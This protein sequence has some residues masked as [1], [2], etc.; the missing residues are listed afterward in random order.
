MAGVNYLGYAQM[1]G[2]DNPTA[3]GLKQLGQTLDQ[4]RALQ[5]QGMLDQRQFANDQRQNRLS[6][7]QMQQA[8]M[9]IDDKMAERGG[10]QDAYGAANPREMYAK[11]FKA[12]Q[13]EK[14]ASAAKERS[15]FA[16]D[17]FSK[18]S[19]AVKAGTIDEATADTYFHSALKLNGMDLDAQGIKLSFKKQ[20]GYYSGP[21]TEHSIFMVDGKPVKY[22]NKGIVE[23]AR[24]VGLDPQTQEPIY[25]MDKD[26]T[27]KAPTNE[28]NY[29]TRNYDK[30]D[31]HITEESQ[32]GGK[33]WKPLA[34]AP[35]YKPGTGGKTSHTEFKDVMALRKEFSSLPEVKDYSMI[36]A[37]SL[38]AKKALEESLKNRSN[39]PVDQT[40]ITT[41]NKLLDPSSVVR[42]SEYAR[43]PQDLSLLS[44]IRGK[45][46]K[47]QSGG[48]GLDLNERQAILR[49]I[50]NFS[51]IADE[52]YNDQVS[53]YSE[54]AKRNGFNPGDVIRLG[55]KQK[56][57]A[58]K[59][60]P[61][62]T[63]GRFTVVEVP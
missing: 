50:T 43:T 3:D 26:T 61:P 44:R 22:G 6:D 17:T 32:D 40:V 57:Q 39:M 31:Q 11:K 25:Q 60:T 21:V 7:L 2:Q 27:F 20:G 55:H 5:R 47:V 46:D 58:G 24:I 59:A 63:S 28:N 51:A 23:K 37:Q 18:V 49:M 10:M 41:F 1:M 15:K 14:E 42:E 36:Q 4:N 48:A 56:P 16:L 33:T 45:W 29:K 12:E 62:R 38:R 35:R 34:T 13:A 9:G 53:Q 8:Q 52:Q 19:E 54:L 30:G